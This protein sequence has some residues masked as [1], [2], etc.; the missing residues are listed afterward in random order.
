[1]S[2]SVALSPSQRA[3]FEE[4]GYLILPAVFTDSEVRR[5]QD[6]ADAILELIINSSIANHRKSGRL[7]WFLSPEGIPHVR[8][9]Q[10]INDLSLYFT[11]ISQDPR[12]LEPMRQIMGD[13]PVLMEE[14]L[15]YKQPLPGFVGDVEIRPGTDRFSTHNDWAFYQQNQYPQSIISSAISLDAC[16]P[17]NGPSHIWPGTHKQHI[18]HVQGPLGWEVPPGAIDPDAG[19]DVL[20]PP[21]S[22][23]LF[24]SLLIHNSRPNETPFPRRLMI[25]SH[26]PAKFPIGFDVRNGPTRLRE[27][28][29]EAEYHRLKARG[30]FQDPFKAPVYRTP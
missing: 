15:N 1:M 19:I 28:P 27:S 17:D 8:K 22:V 16:T 2:V 11:Q 14:K 10:P 13:E 29:W 21:G 18:P 23:M 7:D 30:L 9:I 12:L 20:V 4:Q 5:M 6:E 26:Y 24:H 3:E 25:Y